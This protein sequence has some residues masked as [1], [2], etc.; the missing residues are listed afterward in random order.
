MRVV[1][2]VG[3]R[4]QFVKLA[5]ICR[6]IAQREGWNHRIIHTDQ[7]YDAALSSVFFEELMIPRPDHDLGV[8]SGAHGEQTGEMLKRLEPILAAEKPDWVLLYGD[9]NSTLAGALAAAKLH[10]R[11]A[12]V[13]AGLRSF[14]RAMPEEVN[15]VL[16]DH[17]ADLLLCPTQQ[18]IANLS[19]EGIERGV[20]WTGDVMYDAC[21]RAADSH[22]TSSSAVLDH[23]G[24]RNKPFAVATVHRAETVDTADRLREV[25][26]YLN[27][28]A[29]NVT[30]VFPVHPRTKQ[31]IDRFGID[32]APLRV[33]TPVSY[34]GM[35]ALLSHCTKVFTD[36]GGM[37]KEAY[38]HGKPCVTLRDE[39]E[40]VETIE[41]GWN[42]LWR[43]PDYRPRTPITDYG[44]GRAAYSIVDLI[45]G[46][47]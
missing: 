41:N 24:V 1:S 11:V 34:L 46:G 45:R 22:M 4:P 47:D 20:H 3:A 18:A 37:Q 5:V 13:E 39:T 33:G 6:A 35:A 43:G 7:H 14:N 38:F 25:V 8:G 31:A 36:S 26:E 16:T 44:D 30:V 42:R 27:D 9:T 19:R 21:R 12:H 17:V 28:E 10:V 15:R 40:W 32:T 2:I 29:R 23:F